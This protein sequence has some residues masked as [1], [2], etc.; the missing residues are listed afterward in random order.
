MFVIEI[1]KLFN[2]HISHN[3]SSNS[4]ILYKTSSFWLVN[5]LI[6]L[7]SYKVMK[8][9][10]IFKISFLKGSLIFSSL[11]FLVD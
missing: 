5:Y 6:Y 3:D 2:F 1:D 8:I 11:L 7:R 10:C 9:N 4:R